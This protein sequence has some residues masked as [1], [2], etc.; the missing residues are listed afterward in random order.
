MRLFAILAA[1]CLVLPASAF[2][3]RSHI[4]GPQG[5]LIGLLVEPPGTAAQGSLVRSCTQSERG[6]QQAR[7]E[8]WRA[9]A[10]QASQSESRV[11]RTAT[12]IAAVYQSFPTQASYFNELA[13]GLSAD[14]GLAVYLQNI[15]NGL[16]EASQ[17]SGCFDELKY[18]RMIA[19]AKGA[20]AS[21]IENLATAREALLSGLPSGTVYKVGEEAFAQIPA[22]C[23][24]D[25]GG[26]HGCLPV[27]CSAA[28]PP[29]QQHM[30]NAIDTI[31]RTQDVIQDNFDDGD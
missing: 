16:S 25:A 13:S 21:L 11:A 17:Q 1:A 4:R 15:A 29:C 18:E 9:K 2:A 26:W 31:D 7:V 3:A 19:T 6:A 24:H 14:N 23:Y 10:L 5:M 27:R 22:G 12:S 28:Q 20:I 30:A 8:T